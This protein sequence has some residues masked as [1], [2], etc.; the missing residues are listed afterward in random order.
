MQS[1]I[2]IFKFKNAPRLGTDHN[3]APAAA[4][5]RYDVVH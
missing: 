2:T 4:L 3:E 5:R 1:L